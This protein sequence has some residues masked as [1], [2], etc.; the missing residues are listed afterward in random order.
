MSI[1]QRDRS[2]YW[3]ACI[4]H[5]GKQYRKSLKTTNSADAKKMCFTFQ[6]ELMTDVDSPIFTDVDTVNDYADKLLEILKQKDMTPS[7]ISAAEDAARLLNRKKGIREFLGTRNIQTLTRK[8]LDDFIMQLPLNRTAL[9]KST[10]NKHIS[11]IRQILD[12]ADIDIKMPKNRGKSAERRGCFDKKSYRKLRDTSLKLVGETVKLQNNSTY[13]ITED[14]HDFIVFMMSSMLRPTV[15][16]VYSLKHKHINIKEV[17]G[18]EY[19]EFNLKRKNRQMTVQT[20]PTG[21]Y[22][23]RDIVERNPDYDPEDYLFLPEFEGRRHAMRVM[24]SMFQYLLKKCNLLTDRDGHK[25]TSYSL[26]HTSIVLNLLNSE[27]TPMQIARRADTS[28]KMIDEFYYPITQMNSDL[29]EYL[30]I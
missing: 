15:A 3:H 27:V 6:Q 11:L 28:L 13:T 29:E 24:S 2:P 22:A 30:R 14:L 5:E 19:I 8:D 7:G 17:K 12:L 26:R 16:E 9:S 20:L 21:R 23:Y 25:C 18:T 10:I 1:Y 4:Y